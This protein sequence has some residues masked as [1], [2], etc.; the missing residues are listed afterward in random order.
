MW[1]Q[2]AT[3]TLFAIMDWM[4]Q[5]RWVPGQVT[6]IEL[7][8]DLR[9]YTGVHPAVN[10]ND[11]SAPSIGQ[12][13]KSLRRMIRLIQ[14]NP[15]GEANIPIG[16]F[17]ANPIPRAHSLRGVTGACAT[18]WDKRPI[19]V[20]PLTADLL[21][22]E[23]P[24]AITVPR[25]KDTFTLSY[26]DACGRRWKEYIDTMIKLRLPGGGKAWSRRR[27]VGCRRQRAQ[28]RE[29]RST[30]R[31]ASVSS[32]SSSA[33]G[34]GRARQLLGVDP[35]VTIDLTGSSPSQSSV[36]RNHIGFR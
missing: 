26:P 33:R 28:Q 14:A 18:G 10:K 3:I 7:A 30:A 12:C 19:F 1:W 5:L 8:V 22:T 25:W 32:R 35:V 9:A 2:E 24:K 15:G 23:L 36:Y 29:E 16:A 31:S 11:G 17:P 6:D 21:E 13:A 27:T 34:N 20:S 4:S